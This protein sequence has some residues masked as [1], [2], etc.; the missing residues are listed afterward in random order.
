IE[1]QGKEEISALGVE[2]Q[3][4]RV[5]ARL[6]SPRKMWDQLGSGYRVLAKF[7]IWEDD[8]VL[9][10]PTSALFRT[11]DGWAVFVA[12]N[13]TAVRQ[14]VKVGHQAGLSAQ[15]L[16]GLS[17]G[18]KVIVHPGSEI[19]DRADIEIKEN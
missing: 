5:I 1:H 10:V 12:Q 14:K 15:I 17:E 16:E 4:V 11:D 2:E 9:Q 7:I 13:G 18:D 3:R 19:K 6:E 8:Q